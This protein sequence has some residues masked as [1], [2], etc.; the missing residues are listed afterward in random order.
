MLKP[1]SM[2]GNKNINIIGIDFNAYIKCKCGN[3]RGGFLNKESLIEIWN[4]ENK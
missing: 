3:T 2:C 4:K 1:C